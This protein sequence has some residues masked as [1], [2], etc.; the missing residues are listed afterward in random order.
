[1]SVSLEP[2]ILRAE[3]AAPQEEPVA[4]EETIVEE[5]PAEPL[6]PAPLARSMPEEPLAPE[7]AVDPAPKRE[8]D[9]RNIQLLKIQRPNKQSG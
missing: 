1:M 9:P 8:E 2:I 6:A 4:I 7:T 3:G 5:A